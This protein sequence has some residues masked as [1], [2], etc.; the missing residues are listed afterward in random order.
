MRFLVSFKV[1]GKNQ[2]I[3]SELVSKHQATSNI[4]FN[5]TQMG[6]S[7]RDACFIEIDTYFELL[8]LYRESMSGEP[9]SRMA[10]QIDIDKFLL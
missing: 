6:I 7:L 8:E 9:S 3:P 4:I 1:M 10:T 2:Q 5:L